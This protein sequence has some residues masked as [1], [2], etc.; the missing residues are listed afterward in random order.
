[1]PKEIERRLWKE[2]DKK[3]LTGRR[4]QAYV[5]GTLHKIETAEKRK[6]APARRKRHAT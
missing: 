4:K 1:M 3:G 2:A 5:Y 6:D